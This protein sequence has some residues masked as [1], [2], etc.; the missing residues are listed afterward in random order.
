MPA[1]TRALTFPSAS[2]LQSVCDMCFLRAPFYLTSS[3]CSSMSS[4][5]AHY[6]IPV[7]AQIPSEI[8][9]EAWREEKEG[10]VMWKAKERR[11]KR[12][13]NLEIKTNWLTCYFPG[14]YYCS[15]KWIALNLNS[16]FGEGEINP[17]LEGIFFIC[18]WKFQLVWKKR[19][20]VR[21]KDEVWS[22]LLWCIQKTGASSWQHL[23]PF[24]LAPP[25]SGQTWWND[26]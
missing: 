8:C 24:P 18:K 25:P 4:S 7:Y 17:Q 15:N 2:V 10:Q 22:C 14:Q 19:G 6:E 9:C 3:Y 5:A 20:P 12:G 11:K 21:F 16:Q 1:L 23:I 13:L 26:F